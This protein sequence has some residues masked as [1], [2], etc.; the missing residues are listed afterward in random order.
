MDIIWI[1]NYI[2]FIFWYCY[3]LSWY[4]Y[5]YKK[6]TLFK[7]DIIKKILLLIIVWDMNENLEKKYN[8]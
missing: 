8:K 1:S 2:L 3:E 7:D 5:Q 4:N 6:F